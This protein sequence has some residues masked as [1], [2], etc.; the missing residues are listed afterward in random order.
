MVNSE[1]ASGDG[2]RGSRGEG[3][4]RD[5]G[6]EETAFDES[7]V[8]W[9]MGGR[10]PI[11]TVEEEGGRER[12]TLAGGP[13]VVPARHVAQVQQI[14]GP[15]EMV[16]IE[17]LRTLL[18]PLG[19][20]VPNLLSSGGAGTGNIGGGAG[21]GLDRVPLPTAGAGGAGTDSKVEQGKGFTRLYVG[22]VSFWLSEEDLRKIFEPFGEIAS[23][24]LQRDESG[25]SRGYGFVEFT[26]HESAKKALE[27]NGLDLAG[28]TLKVG[29]ASQ[30]NRGGTG[31]VSGAGNAGR[32]AKS[33]V[34]SGGDEVVPLPG[35]AGEVMDV[36]GEL[37]EGK[38]GGFAMNASQRVML[39]Q[40]L[41]RGEAMGKG[42]DMGM[43]ESQVE[44]RSLMLSNMFNAAMEEVGFELDLAEDVRDE[45]SASYGKVVH[46]HVEKES[47]GLVFVR[48]AKLE[49]SKK[50]V[51]GLSGRWFGG[52]KIR[53]SFVNDEEYARRFQVNG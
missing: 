38:D 46:L 47:Q 51:K 12:E 35:P 6:K 16:S 30:E 52:M 2:G 21:Q 22:S 36:A 49:D 41:S 28:R 42:K 53:A 19:L 9:S 13:E 50:A 20:P 3:R 37:D 8:G 40:Q 43:S 11:R 32:M 17:E 33:N 10:K 31:G 5:V 48:F 25:R 39:M 34:G 18:N 14:T 1:R 44:T 4:G 45:C 15:T 7:L 27:I 29:L 23:L 26:Q 24:Q